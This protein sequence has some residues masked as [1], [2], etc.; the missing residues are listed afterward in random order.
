[1]PTQPGG[2]LAPTSSP[3]VPA[4][5]EKPGCLSYGWRDWSKRTARAQWLQPPMG[6][7]QLYEG[8]PMQGADSGLWPGGATLARDSCA[9]CCAEPRLPRLGANRRQRLET[10]GVLS[11]WVR[12]VAGGS[13]CCTTGLIP[14]SPRGQ[15]GHGARRLPGEQG[16]RASQYQAG[17]EPQRVIWASPTPSLAVPGW[18]SWNGPKSCWKG[19]ARSLHLL[20]LLGTPKTPM[21]DGSSCSSGGS[22]VNAPAGRGE[23]EVQSP[24]SA[25]VPASTFCSQ[26]GSLPGLQPPRLSQPHNARAPRRAEPQCRQASTSV[27]SAPIPMHSTG[28]S[29]SHLVSPG[30][31]GNCTA[32]GPGRSTLLPADSLVFQDHCRG[33]APAQTHPG[34]AQVAPRQG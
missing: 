8:S 23:A 4:G 27:C 34:T 1:M 25:A 28:S 31:A 16:G 20:P 7:G 18:R 14:E 9:S 21:Q 11:T 30:A 5:G 17:L 33:A 19:S 15:G 6:T 24:P 2:P 22:R 10:V 29:T 3:V 26:H 32:L 13:T 12:P